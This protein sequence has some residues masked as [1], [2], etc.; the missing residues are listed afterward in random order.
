M[1]YTRSRD[2]LRARHLLSRQGPVT[3]GTAKRAFLEDLVKQEG[4]DTASFHEPPTNSL[5][6]RM[7]TG[8]ACLL[9]F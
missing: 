6:R 3:F 9:R 8:V 5:I 2:F 1:Y 7:G 4:P